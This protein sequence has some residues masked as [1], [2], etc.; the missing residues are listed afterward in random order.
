[1]G[2]GGIYHYTKNLLDAIFSSD[3]EHSIVLFKNPGNQLDLSQYS[4]YPNCSI[5]L[6]DPA[7]HTTEEEVQQNIGEN[8]VVIRAGF[9][10]RANKHLSGMGIDLMIYPIAWSFSFECGIPYIVVIHDLQHRIQPEFPEVSA[11]GEW[12]RREVLNRNSIKYAEAVFVDSQVGKEDLLAFYGDY[13]SEDRV[14]LLPYAPVVRA[15]SRSMQADVDIREK[16]SLPPRYFFYPAQFWQH[17]NHAR[18]L[19]AIALV[20]QLH[21]LDIPLVLVGSNVGPPHERRELIFLDLVEQARR[22]G[23]SELF[24]YLGS[25]PDDD[26]PRLYRQAV[27]LVMPTFFGPTNIPILEAWSLDCPVITS[28]IRGVRDQAGDAAL[29]VD[30][31]SA[32]AIAQALYRLWTDFSLC[33]RLRENGIKRL[34]LFSFEMFRRKMVENISLVTSRLAS[35]GNSNAH[36]QTISAGVPSATVDEHTFFGGFGGCPVKLH[37]KTVHYAKAW[38]ST[39]DDTVAL[40]DQQMSLV[41]VFQDLCSEYEQP[42]VIDVG[43]HVGTFALAASLQQNLCGCAFEPLALVCEVLRENIALNGLGNRWRIHQ[44]ALSNYPGRRIIK[45]PY[46]DKESGMSCIGQINYSD[47]KEEYVDVVK[48]DDVF[49]SDGIATVDIITIDTQG[50]ELFVLIGGAETIIKHKPD[51]LININW[52]NLNQFD[53]YPNN[54][55]DYLELIGYYGHWVGSETMLF[56]HPGRIS[57]HRKA[58]FGHKPETGDLKVAIV[59][60]HYDL[61][62][63]WRSERWDAADPLS[64]LKKWPSR[65]LYFE[66]T[67]LLQA[68]WYVLPFCHDSK[69]VR[70]RLDKHQQ[71]LDDNMESLRN[72]NDIPLE[73]YDLVISLDPILRPSRKSKTLYAYYQNEHHHTEYTHSLRAPLHGY[74]LFLDHML[75]GPVWVYDLPQPVAFPYVRD[76]FIARQVC[77]GQKTDSVWFD[78]RFIMMLAHGSEAFHRAGFETTISFLENTLRVPAAYRHADYENVIGWGDPL[79]YMREM[80]GCSYYVNLIACGAGQGLCDAAS[81]GLICFGSARLPYHKAICHPVCLCRDLSELKWKLAM[82]RSSADLQQEIRSWQDVALSDMMVTQPVRILQA[83]VDMKRRRTSAVSAGRASSPPIV[84]A[85]KVEELPH[86][87]GLINSTK[88]KQ[89]AQA[90]Y[91]KGNYEEVIHSCNQ[92]LW[93]DRA[94]HELFY[95]TALANYAQKDLKNALLNVTECLKIQGRFQPAITLQSILQ[96]EDSVEDD[97]YIQCRARVMYLV[98]NR[99]DGYDRVLDGNRLEQYNAILEEQLHDYIRLGD[100]NNQLLIQHHKLRLNEIARL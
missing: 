58:C 52:A 68:D 65:Y 96:R 3:L 39:G 72:V 89:Q 43:A 80:A 48:L 97:D 31:K 79:D 25:V 55:Y 98:Q 28:D 53:L 6:F 94:D 63:P 77:S 47:Y 35:R 56:R 92:A 90:E 7:L 8:G 20:R 69:N 44:K 50:C 46:N 30:P 37:P 78:K 23:I 9:N 64:V 19:D 87:V 49:N 14:Y 66:M 26:M 33:E 67:H 34:G 60:Q 40:D 62:G 36:L 17:K 82:V 22:L 15:P 4:L 71:T 2:A 21:G 1:M 95:L 99:F 85:L 93:F 27:G 86:E 91:E 29:L 41:K 5:E 11:G 10:E 70:Q 57:P 51:L 75:N 74:D 38:N 32:Q 54:L 24:Y 100:S 84:T 83:A 61:F 81:L 42:F 59:K 16:Y 76:P 12:N 88:L 73:E 18:I 45:S 13:I